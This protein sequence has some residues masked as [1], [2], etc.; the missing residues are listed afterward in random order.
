MQLNGDDHASNGGV[1]DNSKDYDYCRR[2]ADGNNGDINES[3]DGSKCDDDL[4][5]NHDSNK[6]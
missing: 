4:D 6:K 2:Y 5:Y 1:D 3:D